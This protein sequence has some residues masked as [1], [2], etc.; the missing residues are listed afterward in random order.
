M[1]EEGESRGEEGLVLLQAFLIPDNLHSG[2]RDLGGNYGR[3]RGAVG[4]TGGEESG[5]HHVVV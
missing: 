3:G 1:L 4:Y 5:Y 2:V